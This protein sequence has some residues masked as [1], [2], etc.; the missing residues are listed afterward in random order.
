MEWFLSELGGREIV[1]IV[2]LIIDYCIK[3]TD[4]YH[5]RPCLCEIL[6]KRNEVFAFIFGS[7]GINKL[8]FL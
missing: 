3:H 8:S 4:E 2:K 5:I 1:S 6:G 7:F